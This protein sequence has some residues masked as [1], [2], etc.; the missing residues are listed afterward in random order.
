MAERQLTERQRRFVEAYAACGNAMEAARVAGYSDPNKGRQLVTKSNVASAIAAQGERRTLA[1]IADRKE[2]QTFWTQVARNR[3]V[4]MKHRLKA[5]ELL[6][7][8]K[9]DFLSKVEITGSGGGPVQHFG[10]QVTLTGPEL[11][12]AVLRALEKV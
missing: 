2:R 1:A 10:A 5:S 3:K 9:G 7:K 6:G 8:A 11:E 12:Q 4:D